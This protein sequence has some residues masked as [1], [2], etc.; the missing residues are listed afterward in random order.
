MM[1]QI[2]SSCNLGIIARI[3][4][5]NNWRSDGHIILCPFNRSHPCL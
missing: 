2:I 4:G 3:F 1:F 5:N